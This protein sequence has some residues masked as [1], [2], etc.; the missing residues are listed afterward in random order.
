MDNNDQV[1]QPSNEQVIVEKPTVTTPAY[2]KRISKKLVIIII[3]IVLCILFFLFAFI[4]FL[5]M[6]RKPIAKTPVLNPSPTIEVKPTLQPFPPKGQYVEGQLIISFKN[7]R[8]IEDLSIERSKEIQEIFRQAGVISQEKI[9]KDSTDPAL[10]NFYIL[11]FAKGI[12]IEKAAQ[13]IYEL[14]EIKGAEPN[15]KATIFK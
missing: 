2:S 9:Y 13:K 14:P 3:V 11:H 7:G 6:N 5:N 8:G 4:F 15:A 10:K 1:T 12:D